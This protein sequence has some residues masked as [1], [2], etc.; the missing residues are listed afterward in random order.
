MRIRETALPGL[1]II[2]PRVYRDA[3]GFFVETWHATRYE[4][5]GIPVPFVQD[6]LS[7]SVG[8][9][10]RG[11]HWQWRHPQGKLV[12]V[13]QGEVF[14]VAVDVRPDS[15]TFGRWESVVLS[16]DNCWQYWIPEGFAHGFYVLSEVAQIEY[17][18]TAF[19]DAEGEHGLIWNDPDLAINWPVSAPLLS[20]R[21]Q[22]H[23]RFTEIFGQP[24]R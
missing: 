22:A 23:P 4:E 7:R 24:P 15:P 5:L 12:R 6:N 10:L 11:L 19:Y 9:V 14:D 18:C 21:D 8:N 3:R 20:P 2:E 17:K 1:L 13:T 16:A